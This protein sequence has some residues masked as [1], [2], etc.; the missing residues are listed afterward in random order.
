MEAL[1]NR[2]YT[3]TL[4]RES[5]TPKTN[6]RRTRAGAAEGGERDRRRGEQEGERHVFV[7]VNGVMTP[8]IRDIL[9]PDEYVGREMPHALNIYRC[10]HTGPV[11][12]RY[13]NA[14][15][16]AKRALGD[17]LSRDDGGES[18]GGH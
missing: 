18:A 11:L 9:P 2:G 13:R 1:K 3:A 17:Y 16:L 12:S 8:R 4:S 10:I 15:E 7:A 6:R 5:S 14:R